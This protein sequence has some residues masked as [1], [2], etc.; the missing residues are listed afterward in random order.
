MV[1]NGVLGGEY[2]LGLPKRTTPAVVVLACRACCMCV[3]VLYTLMMQ[4]LSSWPKLP[5]LCAC[6]CMPVPS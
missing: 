2:V 4:H 1:G 5:S 6:F 3:C